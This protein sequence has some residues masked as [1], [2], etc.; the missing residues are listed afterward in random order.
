MRNTYNK[1]INYRKFVYILSFVTCCLMLLG[2]G[3][4]GGGGSW[5]YN[6]NEERNYTSSDYYDSTKSD[7]KNLSR[8]NQV[9]SAY[10]GRNNIEIRNIAVEPSKNVLYACL[11]T[12]P[13]NTPITDLKLIPPLAGNVIANE[14]LSVES[15][16]SSRTSSNEINAACQNALPII[17][18][19]EN[20]AAKA[21]LQKELYNKYLENEANNS[22]VS[23]RA[24]VSHLDE[25]EGQRDISIKVLGKIRHCTL[26]KIS[27]YA[28]FFLDQDGDSSVSA[29]NI[30]NSSL[31]QLA[32]E[33]DNY[34]YPIL[35]D[36][37]GNGAD[38]FWRDV[39]NDGKLSIVFS[40]V[41]N[42]Y[43]SSVVGIFETANLND[44]QYARDMVSIAVKTSDT[45]FEKWFMD[46]RETMPHEMQ[47]I[48][49]FSAKPGRSEILW[50]DEGLSVCAEI[51]YRKKRS[52]AGLTSYSLYYSSE[53]PD[54]PG[55]DARFYYSAY[56]SPELCMTSFADNSDTSITLAHYGQKGLFF[57]YLY[58]Q[59]GKETIRQLCQGERGTEKFKV[60]N[61]SLGELIIDF[62]IAVL[63]EKLRGLEFTNY[64]INPYDTADSKH[65]FITD[66]KLKYIQT[67]NGFVSVNK[68]YFEKRF[69]DLNYEGKF[70]LI[71]DSRGKNTPIPANGG[72]MRIYMEQ[73]KGFNSR[74]AGSNTYSLTFSSSNPVV[75][76]MIRISQ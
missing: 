46:A 55:N 12:N 24:S 15:T 14:R 31:N 7:V 52:E 44:S 69:A 50:I 40:P 17:P 39:D 32:E 62:N 23:F 26:A 66:M 35:K 56:Y 51:L 16:D 61:R 30:S 34:I 65:K 13:N 71:A 2:C 68:S 36:N 8:P 57:Y 76:N 45:S 54:F 10:N 22:K 53:C 49:N 48:V 72:T 5:Y 9:F 70:D 6:E 3:G 28:K 58:E 18:F 42:N 19:R 27:N 73:P 37:Y 75:I 1:S 43:R 11:I 25:V 63:N 59:Y 21:Q 29:P 38:I 4:G 64:P 41:I 74:L 33:F 47:H 20:L 67:S 60:L